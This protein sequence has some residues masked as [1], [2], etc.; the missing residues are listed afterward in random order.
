[1]L[2]IG[3]LYPS[4]VGEEERI[5]E[6]PDP[7][8][9]GGGDPV[10]EHALSREQVE[11]FDRDGFIVLE[12]YMEDWVE[13]LRDELA[14]MTR[15]LKGRPEVVSEPDSDVVRSIFSVERFSGLMDS[16]ARHPKMLDIARQLMGGDV[17]VHQSRINIKPPVD[18]RS[19]PWHSDFETWHVEDGLP[20]MRVVTGWIMLTENTPYNGPLFVIPGSHRR[21]VSCAGITPED[22]H[23]ESLKK[24]RFGSPSRKAIEEL[25]RDGGIAGVFGGPGTVVFH[26]CNIMHGSPDNIS[27]WARSNLFFVYN[28]VHN[29]PL[30]PFGCARPRPAHLANRDF[31]PLTPSA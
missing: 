26:E 14:R 10:G 7:V 28:S 29:T 4:R 6:R 23:L 27:A 30:K 8:V 16:F 12:G 18:G 31:T 3:D 15:E 22:H 9:W 20:R 24:Q 13:P 17:Y 19:F 25:A 2:E 1:M 5:I 11:A 21:Y